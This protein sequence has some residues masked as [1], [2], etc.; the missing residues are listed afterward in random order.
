[1][2]KYNIEISDD[3]PEDI[4]NQMDLSY[5]EYEKRHHLTANYKKFA[6]LLKDEKSNVLGILSAYT[7]LA[8][9]YVDDLWVDDMHR[10][11]GFGKKLLQELESMFK[12][13]GFNNINLV[14]SAFQAPEFYKKCGFEVEFIRVNK[15]N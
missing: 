12:G 7:Y 9:I 2:K 11:K 1:M 4:L 5:E 15:T 13:K 6:L 8:E 14:T 10:G 3:I